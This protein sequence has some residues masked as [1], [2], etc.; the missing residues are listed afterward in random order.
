MYRKTYGF[1]LRNSTE[2]N[3]RYT[4]HAY[5]ILVHNTNHEPSTK[6]YEFYHTP[7]YL[8]YS[9]YTM[10]GIEHTIK[11]LYIIN[12][13][14]I[15]KHNFISYITLRHTQQASCKEKHHEY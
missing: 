13:T 7:K 11:M 3:N 4:H 15:S 1:C 9:S 12:S 8:T 2:I 6:V 10:Y 14:I 5:L